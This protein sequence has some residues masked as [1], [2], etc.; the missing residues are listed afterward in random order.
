MRWK[1]R[2]SVLCRDLCHVSL[3]GVTNMTMQTLS[4]FVVWGVSNMQMRC[5]STK[6]RRGS[7]CRA[8]RVVTHTQQSA[9]LGKMLVVVYN[10][11]WSA[12]EMS[13]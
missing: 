2:V 11:R 1:F 13:C 9:D 7:Y 6:C 4:H 5:E 10:R 8:E 3:C 12:V